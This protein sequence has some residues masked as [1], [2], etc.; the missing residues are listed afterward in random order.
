MPHAN[1]KLAQDNRYANFAIKKP[2]ISQVS[3]SDILI[4]K[5]SDQS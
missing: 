4:S 3:D 1:T 5:L 2:G